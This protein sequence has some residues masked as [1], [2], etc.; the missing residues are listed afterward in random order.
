MLKKNILDARMMVALDKA[1]LTELQKL[2]TAHGVNTTEWIRSLIRSE[3]PKLKKQL[4]A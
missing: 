1:T 4:S 2:K 3:L